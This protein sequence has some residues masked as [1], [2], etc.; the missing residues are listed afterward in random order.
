M[1]I[2]VTEEEIGYIAFHIGASIER[3]RQRKRQNYRVTVVCMTGVGTSQFMFSKF[4]V[5]IIT[6]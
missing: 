5:Q 1:Q 3:S 2:E 4:G 6:F